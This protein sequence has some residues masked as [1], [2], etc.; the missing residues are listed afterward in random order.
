MPRLPLRQAVDLAAQAFAASRVA[1]DTAALVAAYL[2]AAEADGLPSHGLARLPFYASQADVGKVDGFARPTAERTGAAALRI[3]AG[4]GFAFPAIG[5]AIRDGAAIALETGS[6]AV[7]IRRSHH[8][9]VLGHHVEAAADR[10]LVALAFSNTPAAIAPWGGK[11]GLFGTNP[12]AF[13]APRRDAPPLV[14]DLSLSKAA[15]GKIMLAK[16]KGEAI[17]EGWAL[18]DQGQPTTDAQ[19]ALAGTMR[20]VGD[21][22]GAALA[23]MVEILAAALGGAHF[24]F[25]ASSVLDENGP[26]PGLGQSFLFLSPDRLG[27]QSF[28]DRVEILLS[29]I[30]AEPDARLPGERRQAA[31]AK[32]RTDGIDISTDLLAEIERRAARS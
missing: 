17:P 16:Q 7:T 9:G 6:A 1:P 26:P 14:I 12:I 27:G 10:G 5:L 15:R 20:P 3:D 11:R 31:R 19:A 8:A 4:H 13:A 23:L 25:E 28:G 29:A 24:A 2:V 22:K 18:D 21:A 30:Q 32:A